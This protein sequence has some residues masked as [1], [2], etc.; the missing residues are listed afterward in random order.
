M[1]TL[2]SLQLTRRIVLL[3]FLA[4]LSIVLLSFLLSTFLS[5]PRVHP[6]TVTTHALL[7]ALHIRE[8]EYHVISDSVVF[9]NYA[10]VYSRQ[11]QFPNGRHFI[12]DV[13][14]R[15]WRG[16]SFAVVTVVPFD[17]GTRTFTLLREYNIAHSRYVYTF[18]QGM[19]ERSKHQSVENGAAKELEEE[20]HLRCHEWSNL[21]GDDKGQGAP[22]D[23]Y[24][25]ETVHYFLCTSATHIDAADAAHRD[26]EEDIEIVPGVTPA[27][28]KDLI[29][30][31]ALQ[32]NNIAAALMGI[33][34][35]RQLRFLPCLS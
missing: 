14:G 5:Q 21:L 1:K 13:W 29:K 7:E 4:T 3:I 28:L 17:R 34:R 18:P 27:Q 26:E 8:R 24:Q 32:S 16:D 20:A 2:S 35:L 22:Q 25:R 15:A 33:D 30:A 19:F 10:R 31:G 23:K 11:I 6:D 9:D 12:F